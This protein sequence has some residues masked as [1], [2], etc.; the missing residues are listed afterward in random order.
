MSEEIKQKLLEYL[1]SIETFAK[2]ETPLLVSEFIRWE[3]VSGIILSVAC[4]ILTMAFL[5]AAR[6]LWS[7][8]KGS[9]S[10]PAVVFPIFFAL[11]AFGGAVHG[12][13]RSAKAC[14]APRVV[15]IEKI[16]K[17]LK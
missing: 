8:V 4:L 2:E 13:Y 6:K 17:L 12:V 5:Y 11:V 9:A 10:E 1:Q 3:I 14:C 7:L 16:G 15:A